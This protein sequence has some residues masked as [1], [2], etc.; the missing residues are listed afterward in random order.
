LA[1]VM[2]PAAHTAARHDRGRAASALSVVIADDDVLLREGLASLLAGSGLTV[3]GKAG[4]S[5]GVLS[6]VR[7]HQPDLV[8]VDIQMPPTHSTAGLAAAKVIRQDSPHTA[9]LVL[10]ARAEAAHA[11]ELASQ[12][13]IGYLLK[14]RVTDIA[15][16]LDTLRRVA[17]GATVIDAA[18]VQEL[19][20]A[21]QRIDP[22]AGLSAREQQVMELMAQ[23]RSN[24]A[25][26]RQLGVT[27]G[28]VEKHVRSI[29]AKLDLADT[30]DDHRRV[31]AV[32]TFLQAR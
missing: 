32:L 20:S 6:L 30:D 31:Q 2:Q 27:R 24:A 5:V 23:G 12:R 8:V 3:V 19:L 16:F 22:V 18:L 15:E 10:S 13:A 9:I 28:T 25:I 11:M 14:S 1:V 4:D 7:A 26:A 29:M 17:G 21:P